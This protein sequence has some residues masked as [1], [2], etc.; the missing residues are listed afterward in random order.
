MKKRLLAL[1]LSALLLI[2]AV[3]CNIVSTPENGDGTIEDTNTETGTNTDNESNENPDMVDPVTLDYFGIRQVGV[4]RGHVYPRYKMPET[5]VLFGCDPYGRYYTYVPAWEA[6]FYIP[7]D[8]TPKDALINGEHLWI[9]AFSEVDSHITT[10][11][12]AKDG[13]LLQSYS[14]HLPIVGTD[15]DTSYPKCDRWLFNCYEEDI[16]YV[17][18]V[19]PNKRFTG[20]E[21]SYLIHQFE[22]TDCGK[23]WSQ[24]E[25][26]QAAFFDDYIKV[27]DFFTNDLGVIATRM[28]WEHIWDCVY[29]TYD[30]GGTWASM[31][32]LPYPAEWG[33]IEEFCIESLLYENGEY[34]FTL[35]ILPTAGSMHV[36]TFVSDDFL[37]WSLREE[38][39]VLPQ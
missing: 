10:Y 26:Y 39:E 7:I 2:N 1:I 30:G 5:D 4:D 19:T 11:Q 29:I 8:G 13:T 9:L 31:D 14:N 24:V 22:S 18:F 20:T 35:K 6:Y 34:V 16:F 27:F 32:D 28:G 25:G 3:A 36:A 15:P 17:F 37:N 23:T 38:F 33:E 12:F 21:P